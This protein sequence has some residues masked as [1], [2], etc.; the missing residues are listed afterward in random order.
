MVIQWWKP[1]VNFPPHIHG[2][3]GEG[4]HLKDEGMGTGKKLGWK[5]GHKLDMNWIYMDILSSMAW[6]SGKWDV[7]P[8][9]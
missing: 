8:L 4:L 6:S 3:E 7:M 5:I 1:A 2:T 9:S